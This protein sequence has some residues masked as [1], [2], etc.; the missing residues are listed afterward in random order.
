MPATDDGPRVPNVMV[1]PA[2]AQYL[3]ILDFRSGW[4]NGG[5]GGGYSPTFPAGMAERKDGFAPT[6]FPLITATC[7]GT[8]LEYHHVLA[9]SSFLSL[10]PHQAGANLCRPN[11]HP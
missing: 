10:Y 1:C 3:L 8:R 2:R 6:I 4:W 9:E 11:L 5:G 7:P